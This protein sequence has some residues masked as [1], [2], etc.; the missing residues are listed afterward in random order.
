MTPL[1]HAVRASGVSLHPHCM[2]N[3]PKRRSRKLVYGILAVVALGLLSLFW[4]SPPKKTDY[5]TATV[6]RTDLENAV[7]ATG[8]LQALKQVEVGAQVSGQLKSLKWCWAK[9]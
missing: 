5:L 7:L 8:V 3:T 2:Q 9:R 4:F 1:P 6:Q